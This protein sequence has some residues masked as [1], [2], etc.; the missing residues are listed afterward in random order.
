MIK[1]I[2]GVKPN[3]FPDQKTGELIEGVRVHLQWIEDDT[4]GV[5]CENGA[6]SSRKL[7]EYVPQVGDKVV[8][9]KNRYDK[10]DSL[11]KVG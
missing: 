4:I 8:V 11:V 3:A 9:G 10:I 1:E 7:G 2:V 6:V 5:C